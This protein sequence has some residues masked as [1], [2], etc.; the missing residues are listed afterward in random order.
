MRTVSFR[1]GISDNKL[2]GG[3]SFT[4]HGEMIQ[5]DYRISFKY[6]ATTPQSCFKGDPRKEGLMKWHED[7]WSR[8]WL[9]TATF[10]GGAN[11]ASAFIG[12]LVCRRNC[13]RWKLC[14][15]RESTSSSRRVPR[16]AGKYSWKWKS[17]A[18][19]STLSWLVSKFGVPLHLAGAFFMLCRSCV[20]DVP[21]SN[22]MHV[23]GT[24]NDA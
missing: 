1:E 16:E 6:V 18:R 21:N 13:I 2:G 4:L 8:C 5:F 11:M 15:G 17:A 12:K 7:V 19:F 9:R 20:V 10:C 23:W 22:T 14:R 3:W 24:A